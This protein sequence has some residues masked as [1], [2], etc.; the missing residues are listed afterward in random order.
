M[1][2]RD[3]K[4]CLSNQDGLYSGRMLWVAAQEI[5]PPEEEKSTTYRARWFALRCDLVWAKTLE[6]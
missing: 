6:L 2:M 3:M 1:H 4:S 5:R